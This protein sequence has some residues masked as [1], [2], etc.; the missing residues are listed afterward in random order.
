MQNKSWPEWFL[1]FWLLGLIAH[2][3]SRGF[4]GLELLVTVSSYTLL[5]MQASIMAYALV[6]VLQIVSCW[7]QMPFADNHWLFAAFVNT[8]LLVSLV[9]TRKN[10]T[11]WD[12]DERS[13]SGIRI[14][15]LAVYVVAVLHKLNSGF[16]DPA[17]SCAVVHGEKTL[18]QFG[19]LEPGAGVFSQFGRVPIVALLLLELAIPFFLIQRRLWPVGVALGVLFH[20]MTHMPNF[21]TLMFAIY[22]LFIP[23]TAGLAFI[24]RIQ[25]RI[26]RID[27]SHLLIAFALLSTLVNA[28]GR[29]RWISSEI[30]KMSIFFWMAA[31]IGLTLLALRYW[32][33]EPLA[34]ETKLLRTPG[35]LCG[36]LVMVFFVN[37]LSPYLG[38]KDSTSLAM[39][40]NL[41]AR[42]EGGNHFFISTAAFKIFPYVDHEI[43][44][45]SPSW[46]EKKIVSVNT[47][48]ATS[49]EPCVW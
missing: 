40:S 32:M 44:H 46:F 48:H 1:T 26:G 25:E 20:V 39:W 17:V 34:Q 31:A 33:K 9:R 21:G 42:K 12:F 8:F 11:S 29:T 2:C 27:L 36:S 41:N 15:A 4:R 38:L 13:L 14:C 5:I 3:D 16:F 18:A 22:F 37:G 23:K 28:F 47:P 30:L 45:R 43:S 35:L 24:N 19:W 6:F 49:P 7:Q 10:G